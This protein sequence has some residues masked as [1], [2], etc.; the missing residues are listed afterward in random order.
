MG[1]SLLLL[2]WLNSGIFNISPWSFNPDFEAYESCSLVISSS[3]ILLSSELIL[4]GVMS[5]WV[6]RCYLRIGTPTEAAAGYPTDEIVRYLDDIVAGCLVELRIGILGETSCWDTTCWTVYRDTTGFTRSSK[7]VGL[8]PSRGGMY[9]DQSG[10]L[11][12]WG[13]RMVS[14]FPYPSCIEVENSSLVLCQLW[15]LTKTL[16]D[17]F[18]FI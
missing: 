5:S 18:K 11:P 12:S 10:S 2:F 1:R 8:D 7:I 3:G 16:F 9:S 15:R 13:N 14:G 17:K 6:S 4:E